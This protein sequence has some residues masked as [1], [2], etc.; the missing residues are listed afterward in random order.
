MN[1]ILYKN[2]QNS[3]AHRPSRDFNAN[4]VIKNPE[5]LSD[6]MKILLET[7]DKNHHKACWISELIFE[8]HIDWLSPYLDI[9]CETLS[10][11]SN[12]S[13]LRSLSKICLFSANYHMK[14]LKSKEI[15]LAENHLELMIEACFDW[16]ITDKKVATKAYAMRALFQFGKLQDWIYPELQVILEQQYSSGSAGFQFASK[17][18]LGKIAK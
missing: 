5:L 6:L 1:E 11:Y 8:K 15:F 18:I 17:E 14:K 10:S 4:F 16:L 13:A 7:K 2:V 12:E 9:F 3:T